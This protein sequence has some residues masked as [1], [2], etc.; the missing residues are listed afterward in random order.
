MDDIFDVLTN[1]HRR[2]VL[3]ALLDHTPQEDGLDQVNVVEDAHE[4][5]TGLKTLQADFYH[6]HLPKLEQTGFIRW[7]RGSQQVTKGPRFEE[8]CP[9]LEL[10]RD[11]A[12][13]LPDNWL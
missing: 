13:E 1:V 11:H 2:R 10:M 12:D 5:E 6:M 3:V 7:D 9:L 8:I 4:G